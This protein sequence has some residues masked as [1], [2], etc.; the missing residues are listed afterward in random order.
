MKAGKVVFAKGSCNDLMERIKE[1]NRRLKELSRQSTHLP[2][3]TRRSRTTSFE[4][5]REYA[6]QLYKAVENAFTCTCISKHRA[7]LHL[8]SKTSS[9]MPQ[10]FGVMLSKASSGRP[11]PSEWIPF[12]IEMMEQVAAV[13]VRATCGSVRP[14]SSGLPVLTMQSVATRSRA[15]K[16]VAFM[17]TGPAI[18]AMSASSSSTMAALGTKMLRQ[19]AESDIPD[20]AVRSGRLS[21]LNAVGTDRDNSAAKIENL[22]MELEEVKTGCKPKSLG[23]VAGGSAEF[24]IKNSDMSIQ[25]IEP[26][27]MSLHDIVGPKRPSTCRLTKMEKLNLC[28]ALSTAVLS[29]NQTPWMPDELTKHDVMILKQQKD[30]AAI[31][32]ITTHLGAAGSS[33][34]PSNIR[35][36]ALPASIE[37]LALFSLGIVLIELLFG[38]SILDLYDEVQDPKVSGLDLQYA[39]ASR[40]LREEDILQEHGVR[41][42]RAVRVCI[43]SNFGPDVRRHD[44][45]DRSFRSAVYEHVV[46]QLEDCA[47]EFGGVD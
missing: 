41:C 47:R 13:S 18:V 29:L 27:P 34:K 25:G 6:S 36:K 44:L 21:E 19:T 2:T 8:G 1:D 24:L 40:L 3:Q 38:T 4:L 22:C 46:A 14:P 7:G 12:S 42:E 28:V 31:T 17:A 20:N 45:N 11:S 9:N 23:P 16:S 37:N 35:N 5:L 10:S 30:C 32:Y 39:I 15:R 43:K 33:Q 26:I